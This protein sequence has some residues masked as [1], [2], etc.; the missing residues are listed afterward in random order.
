MSD[1]KCPVRQPPSPSPPSDPDG[2]GSGEPPVHPACARSAAGHRHHRAPHP[3]GQG[4]LRGGTGCL[5][6]PRRRLADRQLADRRA[7]HQR[8]GHGHPQPRRPAGRRDPLRPR[9]QFTSWAFTGRARVPGLLASMGSMGDCYDN[10]VIESF[11]GRVQTELLNRQRW[12]PRL[13]L[14]N[15]RLSIWRSSA[16]GAAGTPHPACSPRSNTNSSSPLSP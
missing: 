9:V 7:S 4:V 2:R 15:A 1:L 6:P 11:W 14:A 13:E 16:T 12:R 5:H 10:A 8:P 3:R